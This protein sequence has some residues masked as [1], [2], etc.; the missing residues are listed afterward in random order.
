MKNHIWTPISF[1]IRAETRLILIFPHIQR[2]RVELPQKFSTFFCNPRR[3]RK[4]CVFFPFTRSR[5]VWGG[6]CASL[7]RG[8]SST[9]RPRRDPGLKDKDGWARGIQRIMCAFPLK[10]R[11]GKNRTKLKT[12]PRGQKGEILTFKWTEWKFFWWKILRVYN[13][14]A[15]G[16]AR[17]IFLLERYRLH[18]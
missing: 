8:N 15:G 14:V 13:I 9:N 2:L 11:A 1:F 5:C 4:F 17:E 16:K 7:Y 6:L 12:L 18:A 10:K 3:R